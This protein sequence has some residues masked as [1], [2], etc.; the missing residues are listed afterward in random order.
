MSD[1][2]GRGVTSVSFLYRISLFRMFCLGVCR[3]LGDDSELSL[4]TRQ[5]RVKMMCHS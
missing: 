5:N 4:E 2:L 3:F 1:R